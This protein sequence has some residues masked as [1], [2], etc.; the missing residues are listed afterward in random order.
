MKYIR[1]LKGMSK[2]AKISLVG[3]A[4][5]AASTFAIPAFANTSEKPVQPVFQPVDVGQITTAEQAEQ[6]YEEQMKIYA[7]DKKITYEEISDLCSLLDRKLGILR[8]QNNVLGNKISE[9][10]YPEEFDSKI[11]DAKNALFVLDNNKVYVHPEIEK[12]KTGF[13]EKVLYYYPLL[14]KEPSFYLASD[15]IEKD[16]N[17]IVKE[18]VKTANEILKKYYKDDRLELLDKKEIYVVNDLVIIHKAVNEERAEVIF[19]SEEIEQKKQELETKVKTLEMEKGKF[20]ESKSQ[21]INDLR[22]KIKG[23]RGMYSNTEEEYYHFKKYMKKKEEIRD[24]IYRHGDLT[25]YI[26]ISWFSVYGSDGFLS[27]IN[28]KSER[29]SFSSENKLAVSGLEDYFKG[30]GF[31]VEIDPLKNPAKTMLPWPWWINAIFGGLFP[32]FRNG[33]TAGFVR[34]EF[35]EFDTFEGILESMFFTFLFD[36]IHPLVYPIRLLGTP[37]IF[38]PIRALTG[39]REL[40]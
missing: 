21:E 40:K 13:E 34:R 5:Y 33:I 9:L 12:I 7:E 15:P 14:L 35:D 1:R 17:P 32:L 16:L 26:S 19:N 30:K 11:S 24:F 10:E 8:S 36:G 31:D 4:V 2:S 3:S 23:I 25:K 38:E 22:Q 28:L 6:T 37:F 18:V 29:G 27:G 20:V 39:G